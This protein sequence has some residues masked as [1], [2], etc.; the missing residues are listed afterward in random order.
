MLQVIDRYLLIG[1]L[2]PLCPKLPRGQAMAAES[3]VKPGSGKGETELSNW[4][5]AGLLA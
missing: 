3:R 1:E 5:S 2:I 4:T